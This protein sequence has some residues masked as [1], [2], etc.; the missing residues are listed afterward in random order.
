M[1]PR[2]PDSVVQE[3]AKLYLSGAPLKEITRRLGIHRNSIYGILERA[4]IQRNRQDP[5]MVAKRSEKLRGRKRSPEVAKYAASRRQACLTQQSPEERDLKQRLSVLGLETEPQRP[6]GTYNCDLAAPP[7]AVEVWGGNWHF[8]KGGAAHQA[9]RLEYLFSEGWA[10]V[11]VWLVQGF[12]L[13]DRAAHAVLGFVEGARQHASPAGQYWMVR[14]DGEPLVSGKFQGSGLTVMDRLS[15]GRSL[16]RIED[17][18]L[19]G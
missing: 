11:V 3:V 1:S 18:V 2:H 10:L 19:S 15:R 5:H 9:N 6:I 16:L 14:G 17:D 13:S 8:A 7:V 4:G 12:A